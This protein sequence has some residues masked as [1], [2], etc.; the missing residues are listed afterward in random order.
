MSERLNGQAK[1]ITQKSLRHHNPQITN[2]VF[3]IEHEETEDKDEHDRQFG[4]QFA[5]CL[6]TFIESKVSPFS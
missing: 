4:K 1:L 6:V 5:L 2:R 3:K